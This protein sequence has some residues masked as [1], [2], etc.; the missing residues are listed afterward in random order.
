MFYN[1]MAA[2]ED[3]GTQNKGVVVVVYAVGKSHGAKT[4]SGSTWKASKLISALPARIDGVHIC[5]D[6][7]IWLPAISI[8]KVSVNICT[9]LRIR[10]HCGKWNL[11][12]KRQRT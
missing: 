7:L 8:I 1:L 10:T 5:Y 12:C 3:V 6:S 11:T 2:A 4:D 9:R